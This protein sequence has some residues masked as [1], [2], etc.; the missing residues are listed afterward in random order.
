MPNNFCLIF[1]THSCLTEAVNLPFK[2]R[3][4]RTEEIQ[5][6]FFFSLAP[7]DKSRFA[8]FC[9][10]APDFRH[11]S[12]CTAVFKLFG[13][14]NSNYAFAEKNILDGC[15]K[16]FVYIFRN[17]K[18]LLEFLSPIYLR[19]LPTVLQI[20]AEPDSVLSPAAALILDKAPSLKD[21]EKNDTDF[22]E[23]TERILSCI[24]ADSVFY[25]NKITLIH[26]DSPVDAEQN[27]K[28][29]FLIKFS[30]PA[31]THILYALLAVMTAATRSHEIFLNITK[32]GFGAMIDI[33][34]DSAGAKSKALRGVT[35]L[36][37]LAPF[38]AH[39]ENLLAFAEYVAV[40]HD[41][42]PSADF[43]PDTSELSIT[44]CI[45]V[46]TYSE[47]EFRYREPYKDLD[48]ILLEASGLYQLL[49]RGE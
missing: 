6:D 46:D 8:E 34:T 12:G 45:A 30:T 11:I 43:D 32:S 36:T 14:Y 29:S 27:R 37:C 2:V 38:A 33:K 10:T 28:S 44:L 23:L 20:G 13:F 24:S 19:F 1:N 26:T 39:C 7:G 17:Q 41:F 40:E 42:K 48:A 25:G 31:Y 4:Y 21:S 22:L 15:I 3:E 5:K 47:G 49:T 35:D 16:T 18:G 9:N